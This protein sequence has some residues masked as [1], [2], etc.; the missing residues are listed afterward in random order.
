MFYKR[1]IKECIRRHSKELEHGAKLVMKAQ[2]FEE[3][4]SNEKA[5]KCYKSAKKMFNE[6]KMFAEFIGDKGYKAEAELLIK[7][8][9]EQ[10]NKTIFKDFYCGGISH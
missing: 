10:M 1:F 2:R 9:D 7:K 3:I 5:I 6:A 4:G 8:V